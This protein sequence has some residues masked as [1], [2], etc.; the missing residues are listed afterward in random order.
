MES[1]QGFE[2]SH[3]AIPD[4]GWPLETHKNQVQAGTVIE[5]IDKPS[6]GQRIA[7][8]GGPIGLYRGILPG[9][10]SVFLRNG[11]ASIVMGYANRKLKEHGLR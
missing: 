1:W 8:L 6:L 2:Q 9:S 5:G 4:V 7:Y 10:A 3:G 11:T